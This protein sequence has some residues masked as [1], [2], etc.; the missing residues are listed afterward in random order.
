MKKV[1]LFTLIALMGGVVAQNANAH[2]FKSERMKNWYGSAV[3]YIGW[4]GTLNTTVINSGKNQRAPYGS[5]IGAAFD[6]SEGNTL[7]V[8][9]SAEENVK[10]VNRDDSAKMDSYEHYRSLIQE[11]S[12]GVQYNLYYRGLS[13]TFQPFIGGDLRFNI[14]TFEGNWSSLEKEYEYKTYNND[15]NEA[16]NYKQFKY[17]MKLYNIFTGV[18]KVGL[19]IN[20]TDNFAIAPYAGYG[21]TLT[22]TQQISRSHD[23]INDTVNVARNPD[24]GN[25]YNISYDKN[26]QIKYGDDIRRP[27]SKLN[28]PTLHDT[29]VLGVDTFVKISNQ[30]FL[31]GMEYMHVQGLE[32]HATQ[33]TAKIGYQFF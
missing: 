6:G 1:L 24:D 11:I 9:S 8:A 20:I 13:K 4:H 22:M 28:S 10:Y 27:L 17:G 15:A 16:S 23:T 2:E 14:P 12:I 30:T 25:W 7:T 19:R 32:E 26:G 31:F 5:V 18:A 21:K 3:A 33:L 29:V